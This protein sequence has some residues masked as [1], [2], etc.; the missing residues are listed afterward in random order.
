[1]RRITGLLVL[2]ALLVLL[3]VPY[4]AFAESSAMKAPQ[5]WTTKPNAATVLFICTSHSGY[6]ALKRTVTWESTANKQ[7]SNETSTI[8]LFPGT[9]KTERLH[10][11]GCII[12]EITIEAI[13]G[14]AV[15]VVDAKE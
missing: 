10:R 14:D 8:V 7:K 13:R 3:A 5:S 2:A 11:N 4:T 1:M 9:V 6:G 12:P 15:V